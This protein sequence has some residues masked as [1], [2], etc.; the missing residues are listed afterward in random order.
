MKR[1]AVCCRCFS[2]SWSVGDVH[3]FGCVVVYGGNL[4]LDFE[5]TVKGKLSVSYI[6]QW[7]CQRHRV[8]FM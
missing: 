6:P 7:L 3:V 8:N 1:V 2:S 5:G 4:P